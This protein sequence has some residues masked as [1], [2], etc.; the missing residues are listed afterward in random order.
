MRNLILLSIG[1]LIVFSS[2]CATNGP[3]ASLEQDKMAKD[4][5]A[6]PNKASVFIYRNESLPLA[7]II[8]VN[9]KVLGATA[10]SGYFRLNVV[11]GEYKISTN[12]LQTSSMVTLNA[13]AGKNYFVWH[14]HYV[15]FPTS[16]S[17]L[18]IMSEADG[19]EGVAASRLMAFA[20]S[21]DDFHEVVGSKDNSTLVSK[22][23]RDL[24]S[25]RIDGVITEEE[26]ESK[27]QQFLK[28]L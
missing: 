6:L 21:G 22:K 13:Q 12:D 1:I 9:G 4:F 14:K 23:L 16:R 8:S 2:G 18:Q 26:F 28:E 7:Y 19:R 25:L 27:K 20:I 24:Q 5:S 11:P 10:R 17:V 15:S 3:M